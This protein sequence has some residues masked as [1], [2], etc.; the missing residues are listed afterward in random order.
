MKRREHLTTEG[1]QKIVSIKAVLNKGLSDDL[2]AAFPNIVPA[3]RP[4]V[5]SQIILDPN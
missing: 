3:I 1:L 4:Q 2:K 5:T